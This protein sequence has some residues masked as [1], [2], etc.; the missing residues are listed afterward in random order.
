MMR[1]IEKN[2]SSQILK[3]QSC[4]WGIAFQAWHKLHSSDLFANALR[5]YNRVVHLLVLCPFVYR[6]RSKTPAR[7]N[8]PL[9]QHHLT[10]QQKLLCCCWVSRIIFID[11]SE[12]VNEEVSHH[13]STASKKQANNTGTGTSVQ[14]TCPSSK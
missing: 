4:P 1:P 14:S 6:L 8:L 9:L 5:F 11:S 13:D 7:N 10:G 3:A 2:I 12:I